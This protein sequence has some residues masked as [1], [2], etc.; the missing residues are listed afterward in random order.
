MLRT[1]PRVLV[2][3]DD[4]TIRELVELV[5][6]ED[7]CEVQSRGTS[8]E[9]LPLVQSWRPDVILLDLTLSDG[10]GETFL[11]TTRQLVTED[12]A[13]LLLS[14]SSNLDQYVARLRANGA[15]RKPFDIE[16]LRMAVQQLAGIHAPR[17][18]V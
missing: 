14:G 11:A 15:F 10:D 8:W 2:V 17:A 1:A 12:I 13:V 4:P 3:E 7:G 6:A 16:E 5:L 9:A 18:C